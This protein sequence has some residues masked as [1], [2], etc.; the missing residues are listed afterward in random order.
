MMELIK[1]ENSCLKVMN[2][3]DNINLQEIINTIKDKLIENP[4]IMVFG[5]TCNQHRSIGFFSDTSIGY[6]YSKQLAKS[7]PLNEL[8]Q[9]LDIINVL[10]DM[11]F[12]GILVNRYK[13]GED[14]IS[15]HSDDEKGLTDAGVIILSFG[16]TRKF[17]IRDKN[18][19]KIVLD[20]PLISGQII[21]MSGNFQKEFTHEI[22]IEKRVKGERYSFTFRQHL[23]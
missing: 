7:Q 21:Q 19:K 18:T 15:A 16:A 1:T 12:D 4:E 13:D 20:V 23:Y 8:K 6:Y 11:V 22:P 2:L 10:F 5:K 3:E 9:L 14:Y 17:R